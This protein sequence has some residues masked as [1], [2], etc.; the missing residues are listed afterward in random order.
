MALVSF[1][2]TALAYPWHLPLTIVSFYHPRLTAF[3]HLSTLGTIGATILGASLQLVP[4]V[5]GGRLRAHGAA[6]WAWWCYVAGTALLIVGLWFGWHE[7]LAVGGVLLYLGVHIYVAV[8]GMTMWHSRRDVTLA[9]IV[10]AQ[11]ALAVSANLGA[12]L[13]LTKGIGWLGDATIPTLATHAALMLGGWALVTLAGF[14]PRLALM[15]VGGSAILDRRLAWLDLA[16]LAGGSW[17]LAAAGVARSHPTALVGAALLA[18]GLICLAAQLGR[19]YRKARRTSDPHVPFAIV[20]LIAGLGSLAAIGVAAA[21]SAPASDPMWVVAGWLAIAGCLQTV[22]QGF[23]H[24]IVPFL[25]WLHHHAPRATIGHPPPRPD[26]LVP[27]AHRA[28]E[29]ILWTSGVF[30]GAAGIWLGIPAALDVAAT[31]LGFAL[32]I[33]TLNLLR[34]AWPIGVRLVR[35]G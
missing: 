9:H 34:V 19:V 30:I 3:V 23:L 7:T 25:A 35:G 13:A 8:I 5:T 20:A 31:C 22:I 26:S 1:V 2:L 18:L 16:F 32:M 12:L 14:A 28:L 11:V 24:K 33:L 21:R 17:A 15:F 29:L 4:V 10:V 27:S 6:R